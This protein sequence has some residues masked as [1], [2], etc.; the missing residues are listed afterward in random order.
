MRE[1]SEM[2]PEALKMPIIYKFMVKIFFD[3]FYLNSI[4]KFIKWINNKN[5][6]T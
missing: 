3:F 5:N 1:D 6:L 2:K 4:I